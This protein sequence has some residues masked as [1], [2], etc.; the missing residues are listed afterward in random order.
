MKKV[1]AGLAVVQLAVIIVQFFLAAMGAFNSAPT[2]QGFQPHIALG[3][4]TLIVAVLTTIGAAVAR[5]PGRLVGFAGLAVGLVILQVLIAE[6][7]KGIGDSSTAGQI[8]FGLHGINGLI[9]MGVTE[10]VQRKSRQLAWGKP[11]AAQLERTA[12]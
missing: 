12:S 9:T 10:S 11:E 6:V 7:A 1:V 2:E 5:M 8:I 4:V 3:Y